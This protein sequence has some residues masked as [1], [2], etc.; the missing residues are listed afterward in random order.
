MMTT[1]SELEREDLEC[2]T[3]LSKFDTTPPPRMT[4]DEY[5][6]FVWEMLQH[7]PPEQIDRQ[8]RLEKQIKAAFWM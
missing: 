7:I 1:T 5:C 8:K 6:D 4:M 2:L 3:G